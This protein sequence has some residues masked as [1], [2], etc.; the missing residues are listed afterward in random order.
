[1]NSL[2]KFRRQSDKTI[3]NAVAVGYLTALN[4]IAQS[5]LAP[6]DKC[7]LL[8]TMKEKYNNNYTKRK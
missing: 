6:E 5:N 2:E 3:K 4:D 8:E 1:M 7:E